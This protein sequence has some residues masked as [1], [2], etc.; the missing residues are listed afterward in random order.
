MSLDHLWAMRHLP[1]LA[2]LRAFQA[3]ARHLSFKR[4]AAEPAQR[5]EL[6]R[7]PQS[8]KENMILGKM[9]QDG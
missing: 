1:P 7:E 3:A 8:G 5:I 2:T 4:A 9:S 6:H